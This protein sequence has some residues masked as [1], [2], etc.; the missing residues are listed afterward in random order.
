MM[1]STPSHKS[2]KLRM[3][4]VSMVE[5]LVTI[6]VLAVGLL[7]I[8]G[9]QAKSL[10]HNTSAYTRSQAQLLAY[11]MLDRLRANRGGVTFGFYDNLMASTPTPQS[12]IA[13]GCTTEE[14][15][16]YDAFEWSG[17]L[18]NTLAGG[19]GR[20]IRNADDTFTITV[21]WDDNRT[22]ATG[23]ACGDDPKVDLRCFNLSSRL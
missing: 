9:M 16:K 21:M 2:P 10:K 4:G 3:Q 20:V 5:I 17:L 6:F 15:A 22:G 12:C 19:I 14:I 18:N 7:G 13:T 8:A 23:T 1:R 11:D